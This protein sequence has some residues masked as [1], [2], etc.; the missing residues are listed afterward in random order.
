MRLSKSAVALCLALTTATNLRQGVGAF[1]P[2]T[3]ALS[4]RPGPAP[5]AA[6]AVLLSSPSSSTG[7][8]ASAA[9]EVEQ[10]QE[11]DPLGLTTELRKI[12]D[13]FQK[14]GDVKLRY[15]QLLYMAQNG[16]EPMPEELKVDEN[17]V[18]GCLST[19]HV[20]A[21]PTREGDKTL[22]HFQGD[23][24][25]LLTKG[26]VALLIRYVLGFGNSMERIL[27]NNFYYFYLISAHHIC[28]ILPPIN[29]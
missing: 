15:K 8:S 1:V 21:T 26:L 10:Q 20:H 19:V 27:Y 29:L 28:Q 25:G 7:H 23:S 9:S 13:A 2:A 6:R 16:L 12:T 3:V 24:D 22:I 4:S 11:E 18:L 5:P 17:K 14:I